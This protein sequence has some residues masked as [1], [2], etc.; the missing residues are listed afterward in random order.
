MTAF[1]EN[2]TGLTDY[3]QCKK[4]YRHVIKKVKVIIPWE[5]LN[6]KYVKMIENR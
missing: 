1:R 5:L 4:D 3:L 6:I 2:V